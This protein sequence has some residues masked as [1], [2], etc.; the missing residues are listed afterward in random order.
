MYGCAIIKSRTMTSGIL[1]LI[2]QYIFFVA[3]CALNYQSF[4]GGP[5]GVILKLP[6]T[7]MATKEIK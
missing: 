5:T 4:P 3:H 1:V 2:G 6:P 7:A